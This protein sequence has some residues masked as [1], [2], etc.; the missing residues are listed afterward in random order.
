[1][2]PTCDQMWWDPN[3]INKIDAPPQQHTWNP[4]RRFRPNRVRPLFGR[5]RGSGIL[6]MMNAVY[7]M[8]FEFERDVI[9]LKFPLLYAK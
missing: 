1:M 8:V 6:H 2:G 7:H 9:H 5:N 4:D 3:P